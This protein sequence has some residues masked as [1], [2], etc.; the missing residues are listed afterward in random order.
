MINN[1]VR[2]LLT[3]RRFDVLLW[4]TTPLSLTLQ[5]LVNVAV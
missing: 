3:N 5:V 2:Y 1:R 4:T